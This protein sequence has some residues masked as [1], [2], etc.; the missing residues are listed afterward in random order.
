MSQK[1]DIAGQRHGR[2]GEGRGALSLDDY[3]CCT[4]GGVQAPSVTASQR[5]TDT[6]HI[7]SRVVPNACPWRALPLNNSQEVRYRM[8]TPT[9]PAGSQQT[10]LL[11]GQSMIDRAYLPKFRE[12]N[13]TA[14]GQRRKEAPAGFP[15]WSFV[16]AISARLRDK[17]DVILD[18]GIR[19]GT[20]VL[21]ALAAGAKACSGGRMYLYALAAAGQPG[22]EK[23]L[24]NMRTEIERDMK[25]MGVTKVSQLNRDMLRF[26]SAHG[27]QGKCS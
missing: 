6:T 8:Q 16:S 13:G 1:P 22:V 25:L 15:L 26:R 24:G 19:R 14:R 7:L 18:G 27:F 12:S 17:I 5:A 3:T 23:A 2:V 20:H 11:E 4:A 9:P 10:G 21:K